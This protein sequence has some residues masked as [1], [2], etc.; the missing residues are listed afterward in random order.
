[1][2]P[3]PWV[4]DPI[5]GPWFIL[6]DEKRP[7]EH[8]TLTAGETKYALVWTKEALA[9]EF[10]VANP[11]AKGLTPARLDT[12]ELKATFLEAARR[13]GASHVLFDYLPGMHR[14]RA[15]SVEALAQALDQKGV[16]PD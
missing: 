1:M 9:A 4:V 5:S 15:A 8:L 2:P 7:G 12:R 3:Y 6:E 10:V 16:S 13:L 14:A 11:A